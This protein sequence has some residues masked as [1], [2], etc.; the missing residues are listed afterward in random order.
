MGQDAKFIDCVN[1][2]PLLDL[3]NSL[4]T[5]YPRCGKKNAAVAEVV[6]LDGLCTEQPGCT[7]NPNMT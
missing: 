3:H 1:S 6:L 7:F 4:K 2:S 5:A